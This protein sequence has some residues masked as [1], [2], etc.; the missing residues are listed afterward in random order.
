MDRNT[1]SIAALVLDAVIGRGR[2]LDKTLAELT[3]G[4]ADKRDQAYVQELVY[5]VLRWYWRLAPQLGQLL[6]RPLRER[7]RDIEMLLLVGLYQQQYL[8]TAT[9]AA[10]SETVAACHE[11][12]KSWARGLINGTLR[13]AIRERDALANVSNETIAGETSHPEWFVAVVTADWPDAATSL[14]AANNVRPPL[15]LR[16]N[17]LQT[18]RDGYLAQLGSAGIVAAS[19]RHATE[20]IQLVEAVPVDALPGFHD[21]AVSVQDEAAQLAESVLQ[22][23]AGARVLDACAAPGGKTAH[24]LERH[25]ETLELVALDSAASRVEKLEATL[26]RLRVHATTRCADAAA[27]DEWWDGERFDRILID[28]PCSGSGVIRRH[29]DIKHH[30]RPDDIPVLAAQPARLLDSLWPLL[31]PGGKL[32]YATCSVLRAENDDIIGSFLERTPDAVPEPI[33]A[34]WG[35]PTRHGRQVLTGTDNMDGFYFAR[36]VRPGADN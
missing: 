30:R 19:T 13:N 3:R 9:H 24:I 27:V 33:A 17:A 2:S 7:D 35:S 20:G 26:A 28:A 32:V 18:T 29:P 16:V 22:V 8:A 1:R 11:L 12:R 10:V 23:P 6:K 21:G 31:G 14:F 25:P 4:L 15:T 36:L 5:G 34:T